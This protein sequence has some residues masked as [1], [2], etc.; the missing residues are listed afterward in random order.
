MRP[1]CVSSAARD[2]Q[3]TV[4]FHQVDQANADAALINNELGIR[5]FQRLALHDFAN[6]ERLADVVHAERQPLQVDQIET[7]NCFLSPGLALVVHSPFARTFDRVMDNCDSRAV[8][9]LSKVQPPTRRPCERDRTDS[10][11]RSCP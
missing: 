6:R 2:L 5:T 8:D 1:S 10:L 4:S 9:R 7:L 11:K 3:A